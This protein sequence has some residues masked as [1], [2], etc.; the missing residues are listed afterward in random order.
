MDSAEFTEW[1][2]MY[3]IEPFGDEVA[4]RR[5]GDATATLANAHF[6]TAEKW[7]SADE[8]ML[9]NGDLSQSQDDAEPEYVDDP[10]AHSNLIRA[11][12]FKLPPKQ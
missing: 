12:V 5:H 1:Q 11:A 3:L 10:V 8:F 9:G 2:A 7:F 4:D 6:G